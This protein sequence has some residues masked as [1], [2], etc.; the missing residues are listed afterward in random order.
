VERVEALAIRLVPADSVVIREWQDLAV[1]TGASFFSRPEWFVA[2]AD[3][4]AKGNLHC[5]TARE[6]SDLVGL[7]PVVPARRTLKAAVNS[8]TVRYS[9]LL[10]PRFT[11]GEVL[12]RRP[13]ECPRLSLSY[14]PDTDLDPSGLDTGSRVIWTELRKSPTVGT[15]G[16]FSAW[17][18]E[19]LSPSRLKN[20]RR[21]RRRLEEMGDVLVEICDGTG[22]LDELLDEGLDLEAAGWKGQSGTAVKSRPDTYRFYRRMA[23]EAAS[24]GILRLFF[25]RLDGAAIAFSFTIEEAGILSGL[26][27]AFDERYRSFAPGVLLSRA[28]LEYCFA[29]PTLSRFDF[30]GEAE[31]SKLD[32]TDDVQVQLR[33]EVPP[34][35]WAGTIESRAIEAYWDL[36]ESIRAKVPLEMRERVDTSS[37]PAAARSVTGLIGTEW[38]ARRGPGRRNA[39]WRATF[40]PES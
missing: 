10:D 25:L 16:D 18:K 33:V 21:T 31:R 9:P 4:F 37:V 22:R 7:L 1:A 32:W 15:T 6:G 30:L 28:R 5:L 8:E 11:L 3:A 29:H 34:P 40:R 14:L 23:A 13:A 17:E 19:R 27:I 35:G 38:R 12:A 39:G 20:L 36:R 24:L 26:K 2:W